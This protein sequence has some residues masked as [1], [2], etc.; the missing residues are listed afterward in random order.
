MPSAGRHADRDC[1]RQTSSESSRCIDW[2]FSGRRLPTRSRC[3]RKLCSL[4]SSDNPAITAAAERP[5]GNM[6]MAHSMNRRSESWAF[7]GCRISPAQPGKAVLRILMSE[8]GWL[9]LR[10]AGGHPGNDRDQPHSPLDRARHMRVTVKS[11]LV[12]EPQTG[13]RRAQG[14]WSAVEQ[15]LI[16]KATVHHG[17]AELQCGCDRRRSRRYA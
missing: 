17:Q 6:A 12:H 7:S 16:S 11:T 9:Q 2:P 13:R 8:L 1:N 14:F 3:T 10:A 5:P 15:G 4:R